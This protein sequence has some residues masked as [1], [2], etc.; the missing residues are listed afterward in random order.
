MWEHLTLLCQT[1]SGFD[2]RV[3]S[4]PISV[5]F[6]SHSHPA[7]NPPPH[8]HHCTSTPPLYYL[9]RGLF[10]ISIKIRQ[11]SRPQAAWPTCNLLEVPVFYVEWREYL[12][13]ALPAFGIRTW[14]GGGSPDGPDRISQFFIDPVVAREARVETPGEVWYLHGLTHTTH[15]SCWD[16][17]CHPRGFDVEQMYIFQFLLL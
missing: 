13:V 8:H 10:I 2:Q 1:A 6:L 4:A 16:A 11:D 17:N 9:H 12:P 3:S 7:C 15:T 5:A 14:W